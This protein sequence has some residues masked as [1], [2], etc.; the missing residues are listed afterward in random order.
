MMMR[1]KNKI[2]ELRERKWKEKR[3]NMRES[4]IWK[5]CY[6]ANAFSHL[7]FEHK[8]WLVKYCKLLLLHLSAYKKRGNHHFCEET[9]IRKTAYKHLRAFSFSLFHIDSQL[10]TAYS[11]YFEYSNS[12]RK[13]KE[14]NVRGRIFSRESF[15]FSS[16]LN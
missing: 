2:Y 13:V 14:R 16:S 12:C 10:T 9:R 8:S 15:T 7:P 11:P 6:V 5:Q 1:S 4:L 3:E